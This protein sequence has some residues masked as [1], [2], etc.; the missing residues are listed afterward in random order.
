[1][2]HTPSVT[3]HGVCLLPRRPPCV[4]VPRVSQFVPAVTNRAGRGFVLRIGYKFRNDGLPSLGKVFLMLGSLPTIWPLVR[5]MEA[6]AMAL[7]LIVPPPA[8]C[9]GC[10]ASHDG[11]L[12][13]VA[14]HAVVTSCCHQ[15]PMTR[16]QQSNEVTQGASYHEASCGCHLHSVDRSLATGE[17]IFPIDSL[18]PLPTAQSAHPDVAGLQA[19][20]KSPPAESPTSVPH[21]ILH[22]SWLI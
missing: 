3:A 22:C 6:L 21:R 16:S 13:C 10:L 9:A 12:Q 17:R 8:R 18:A 7:G 11:Q 2:T 15:L 20:A 14:S 5:Y 4:K 19:V 1:V